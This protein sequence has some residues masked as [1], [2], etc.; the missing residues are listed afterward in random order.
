MQ[1]LG[2]VLMNR[3]GAALGSSGFQ[4]GTAGAF[5]VSITTQLT[6]YAILVLE[7]GPLCGFNF[8]RGCVV[9]GYTYCRIL[10]C[11]FHDCTAAGIQ[12][13]HILQYASLDGSAHSF[14]FIFYSHSLTDSQVLQ[15]TL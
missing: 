2:A 15:R 8:V 10:F 4:E 5:G 1:V 11:C 6:M 3:H 7:C 12:G 14:L 13:L 9:L